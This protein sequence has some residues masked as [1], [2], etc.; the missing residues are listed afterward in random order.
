[1]LF[2]KIVKKIN[3]YAGM[4]YVILR[5]SIR[6]FYP[7][8]LKKK[9]VSDEYLRRVG[10]K[11]DWNNLRSYT[12]KMQYEKLYD[13]YPLKTKCSDKIWVREF[14]EKKI[15]QK[16]LI[17]IYG[18]WERFEEIDFSK[19]PDSFVLKTNHASGT[20]AVIKDKS[21]I[22]LRELKNKFDR[23]MKTKFQYTHFEMHYAGIKPLIYA[24][25]M[26]Q[27]SEGI[28]D[29]KFMCFDG[30][31]KYCWVDFDRFNGHKRK[32]YDMEWNLQ[33]WN[34]YTYGETTKNVPKPDNFNEM[35]EI[36][37]KLSQGFSHVRVDLYNVN[38]K[39]Y[40]GELTFTNGAGLEKIHPWEWDIKL[41]EL[42]KLKIDKRLIK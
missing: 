41:G 31:P 5:N 36:A 40:F 32:V 37:R 11:L 33:E 38:G 42:W 10:R 29:Y 35:V 27:F 26:L 17:P 13:L 24:E 4:D 19:L 30:E 34:Q 16:Y 28:E 22:N 12:E 25:K 7:V 3:P 8:F 1:M 15:G 14:V 39:I 20:V 9:C 6:R 23:W 2:I 18:V 21:K